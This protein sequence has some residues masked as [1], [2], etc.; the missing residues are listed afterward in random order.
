MA[1]HRADASFDKRS[2][3]TVDQLIAENAAAIPVPRQV[4]R[5][6]ATSRILVV[7]STGEVT[8]S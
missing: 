6:M 4:R 2:A 1:N 5:R 3:K 7:P 8:K